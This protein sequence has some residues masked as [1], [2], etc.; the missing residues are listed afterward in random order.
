MGSLRVLL[1]DDDADIRFI[2]AMSLRRLGGMEVRMADSG[3]V[4]VAMAAESPPEVILL[5][6]MMPEL[7]GERTLAMLR[8]DPRTAAVPVV[9]MTAKVMGEEIARWLSLGACG[10]IHKPFDPTALP[11]LVHEAIRNPMR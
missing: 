2:A 4:G 11:R 10:V 8:T 5:D 7:D 3:R 1:I 9:F 6:V